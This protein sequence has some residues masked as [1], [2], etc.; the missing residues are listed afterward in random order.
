MSRWRPDIDEERWIVLCSRYPSLRAASGADAGRTGNW[1]SARTLSRIGLFLLGLMA[2][3]QAQNLL[4]LLWRSPADEG[5]APTHLNLLGAALSLLVAEALIARRRLFRSGLEEG[6][7][8]GGI[9]SVCSDFIPR[10]VAQGDL[11]LAIAIP[12]AALLLGGLRL[13]NPLAV[14]AAALLSSGIVATSP[15]LSWTDTGFSIASLYCLGVGVLALGIGGRNFARPSHDRMLD[16]L[17]VVMPVA[18][19][20]WALGA[21]PTAFTFEKL[22]GN[23]YPE[24]LP[25][26]VPL[27]FAVAAGIVG[28]RQRRHAPLVAMLAC[29]LCL[30]YELRDITGL[31]LRWLLVLWGAVALLAC[32]GIDRWL[33]EPRQ[34]I[35][36][37]DL[38]DDTSALV[39]DALRAA[40]LTPVA[41]PGPSPS[42]DGQG[43]GFGGAGASGRY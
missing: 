8:L 41:E 2:S 38:G 36:T 22:S 3:T 32:V 30:A 31:P 19:F 15:G 28:L 37:A 18:G 25:V 26:L 4:S 12:S 34:G 24:L 10:V 40:A 33:R 6:L 5:Y 35:T 1:H 13:L 43:G 29:K 14:A 21:A 7:W 17:V 39:S 23:A 20:G 16:H 11:S 42:F 27:V 9:I